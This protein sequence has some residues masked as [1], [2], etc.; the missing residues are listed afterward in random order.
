MKANY[1]HRTIATEA[2]AAVRSVGQGRL[3]PAQYEPLIEPVEN[4][5][6]GWRDDSSD[7]PR[8]G[9]ESAVRP[10]EM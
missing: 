3:N 6:K 10:D 8:A 4:R 9:R 5:R 1:R 7:D 2:D